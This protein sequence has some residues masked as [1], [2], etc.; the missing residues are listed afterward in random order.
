MKIK[1]EISNYIRSSNKK[2]DI[3]ICGEDWEVLQRFIQVIFWGD[4]I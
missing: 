1:G 4:D 3:L 2:T